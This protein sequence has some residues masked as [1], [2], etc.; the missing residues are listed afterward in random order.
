VVSKAGSNFVAEVLCANSA[1]L[2][3]FDKT[4]SQLEL[5]QH[6]DLD[7]MLVTDLTKLPPGAPKRPNKFRNLCELDTI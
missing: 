5:D 4:L 1:R 2:R 7:V 3:H 6:A